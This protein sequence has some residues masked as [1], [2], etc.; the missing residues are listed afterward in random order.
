VKDRE[1]GSRVKP[2]RG[3]LLACA[4]LLVTTGAVAANTIHVPDQEPTIQAGITAASD[5]DT[6]LVACDTYQEHGITMKS[7]VTLMSETGDPSCV[8]ID[9]QGNLG[10]VFYILSVNSS[11]IAGFTITGGQASYGGGVYGDGSL[12]TFRDCVFTGNV[13][14]NG[15][16][17]IHWDD[18]TVT[19]TDCDFIGNTAGDGGG[20]AH[21]NYSD[22]T[23]TGCAFEGNGAGY[24]GGLAF[25]GGA[26]LSVTGSVFSDNT[27]GAPDDGGGGAY[28]ESGSVEFTDCV[29]DGN[30]GGDY[31]G[32]IYSL[33]SAQLTCADCTFESNEADYGGGMMSNEPAW[34]ELQGCAF[35]W[36]TAIGG[37]GA[38]FYHDPSVMN[39]NCIFG[40]N[41]VTE[42]GGGATC[43]GSFCD[44]IEC[45]FDNNEGAWGVALTGY[46]SADMDIS[47]S[48]FVLNHAPEAAR[49]GQTIYT[50]GSSGAYIDGSIIA[51]NTGQEAVYCEDGGTATLSCSLV[52]GNGGGDWTGC[53]AGQDASNG[54]LHIDPRFC[55]LMSG[56]YELCSNSACL[57]DNNSCTVLM[58]AWGEGCGDCDTPVER[59]TWGV[60]K[61]RW[62]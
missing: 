30:H 55:G 34:T 9:G 46:Y 24:G 53:I 20:G 42:G 56:N 45:T 62:R 40:G 44:F 49:S 21:V 12:M 57:P 16:G 28:V 14:S 8:T 31:A 27:A 39:D 33:G 29:F 58:G 61:A 50:W 7:G 43:D 13:A 32:G 5:G 10:N 18:G 23:I 35:V 59:S 2:L 54:N 38:Y 37:G 4:T 17:G 6:V 25:E 51:F 52:Y 1:G 3:G 41:A 47:G 26:S 11:L 60:I 48:T 15:G 19:L 36:N 22:A